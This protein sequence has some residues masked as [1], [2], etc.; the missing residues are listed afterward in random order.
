M[1]HYVIDTET[2]VGNLLQTGL[3]ELRSAR[4]K[5]RR[6]WGIMDAAI[7]PGPDYTQIEGGVFGIAAGE[8][9]EVFGL[10]NSI[11][12]DLD[13]LTD[14]DAFAPQIDQGG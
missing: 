13:G 6:A 4:D 10:V 1:A 7:S 5:I 9:D 3:N 12:T 14:T 8:G 2:S 11:K